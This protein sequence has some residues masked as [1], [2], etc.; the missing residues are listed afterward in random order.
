MFILCNFI[1][2]YRWLFCWNLKIVVRKRKKTQWYRQVL[3]KSTRKHH[4]S[5]YISVCVLVSLALNILKA[6]FVFCKLEYELFDAYDL[7]FLLIEAYESGL[8]N[9]YI[10]CRVFPY[11]SFVRV[12]AHFRSV[13][14]S[15]VFHYTELSVRFTAISFGWLLF[16][17]PPPEGS[18]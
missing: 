15:I 9:R 3:H 4:Q 12:Y 13:V 2:C 14:K 18:C 16:E 8:M 17:L 11:S 6:N 1:L 10:L 5:I 7:S